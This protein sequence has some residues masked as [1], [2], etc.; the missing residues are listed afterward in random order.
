[1]KTYN[2]LQAFNIDREFEKSIDTVIKMYNNGEIFIHPTDTVY[3]IGGNPLN[4][5]SFS[6]LRKFSNNNIF[7]EST[8]L[9]NSLSDLIFYIDIISE[10]HFD[11]LMSIWP[12]PV[13]VI[14]KLNSKFQEYFGSETA[15][16]QIPNNRFCLR[17]LT[18]IR[19][20]L[21]SIGFS[22]TKYVSN[23]SHEVLT[24][25]YA[26]LVDAI[27]YTN[28][29]SFN[30]DTSLVDLTSKE[31]VILKESKI[32]VQKYIDKYHLMS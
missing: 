28:S 5:D 3:S 25:E 11:F 13:R 29:E 12:N 32:K 26:D 19:N 18:E 6:R 20:P 27:F 8:L 10:R 1:M 21:L 23:K 22:D 9:I 17:L 24:E 2:N 30:S 14:F 16:F 4:I 31:P 15:I 7:H